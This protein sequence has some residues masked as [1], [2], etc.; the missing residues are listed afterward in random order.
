MP[1]FDGTRPSG[2]SPIARRG[3]EYCKPG[4]SCGFGISFL[5]HSVGF[6]YGIGRR[7]GNMLWENGSPRSERKRADRPGP[8][9]ESYH[10][11][12]EE[13]RKIKEEA[14]VLKDDLKAIE[15]RMS[16]LEAEKKPK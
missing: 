14:E 1:E 16:D 8:Y 6:G 11:Q 2:G 12:E 9:I 7:Y 3:R 5:R 15:C 4:V 13:F 10:S